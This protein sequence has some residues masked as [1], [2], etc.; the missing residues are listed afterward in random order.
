MK[1]CQIIL[2]ISAIVLLTSKSFAQEMKVIA[3]LNLSGIDE[4]SFNSFN[5]VSDA[6]TSPLVGFHLGVLKEFSLAKKERFFETGLIFTTKGH[7]ASSLYPHESD[8]R[9]SLLY[10]EV[11][12]T[13]KRQFEVEGVKMSLVFGPYIGVGIAGRNKGRLNYRGEMM[14]IN[15]PVW[16]SEPA[17]FRRIDG[18]LTVGLGVE[19]NDLSF[20]IRYAF[21]LINMAPHDLFRS[22]M[23]FNRSFSLSVGYRISKK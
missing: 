5:R 22:P 23:H 9:T 13:L 14:K 17:G 4:I 12:L 18:G 10:A 6:S 11:P 1:S 15:N 3:G 7:H 20:G 21:G 16:S 19:F 2:L 8:V